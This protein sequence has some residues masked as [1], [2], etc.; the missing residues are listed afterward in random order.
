V[1]AD[2]LLRFIGEPQAFSR[3][4][5]V[6]GIVGIGLVVL[7]CAGIYIWTLP[8]GRLR[9]TRGTT[10]VHAFLTRRRFVA[11]VR[12]I[13]E[14]FRSGTMTSAQASAELSH[15]VRAFLAVSTGTRAQY[16]HVSEIA[17]SPNAAVAGTAPLLA[18]LTEAQFD[19]DTD[20]D[21]DAL[22]RASE[23]LITTWS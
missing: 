16:L 5:L 17:E 19:P 6:L 4:W 1:P 21:V 12:R 8:A 10:Q 13:G 18:A 7:I 3:W 20:V 23:E 2:D 22:Q 11:A 9:S 14:Q 15:A